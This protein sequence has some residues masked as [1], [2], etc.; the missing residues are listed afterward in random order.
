MDE[1][2]QMPE[3]GRGQWE[4]CVVESGG[5]GAAVGPLGRA[6]LRGSKFVA[7]PLL[8]PLLVSYF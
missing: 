6:P 2:C 3:Y 7:T 8:Q 1:M 4:K 5:E